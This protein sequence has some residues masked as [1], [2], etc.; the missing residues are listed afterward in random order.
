MTSSAR[1]AAIADRQVERLGG[2]QID[3]QL[4]ARR[5]NDREVAGLFAVEEPAGVDADLLLDLSKRQP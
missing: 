1:C 2:F 5:F 4:Q 3:N